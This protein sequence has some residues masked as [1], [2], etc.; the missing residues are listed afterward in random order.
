MQY[1]GSQRGHSRQ[2]FGRGKRLSFTG[3]F[4]VCLIRFNS[5]EIGDANET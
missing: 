3:R 4:A 1:N 2:P 5:E